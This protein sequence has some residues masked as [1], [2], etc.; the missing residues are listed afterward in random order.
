MQLFLI[1]SE[2]YHF[3]RYYINITDIRAQ[4]RIPSAGYYLKRLKLFKISL[5]EDSVRN[6]GPTLFVWLVYDYQIHRF[7]FFFLNIHYYC[8]C[9]DCYYH[10]DNCEDDSK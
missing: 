7:F 5:F 3:Y 2:F 9:Y 6:I 4:M 8:C 10:R 1:F